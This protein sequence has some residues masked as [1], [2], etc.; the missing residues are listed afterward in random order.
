[1][2]VVVA[3]RVAGDTDQFR[4]FVTDEANADRLESVAATAKEQGAIHH[5]FAVGDGFVLVVDE[6]ESPEH[7]QRFFQGNPDVAAI[8]RDSGGQGEPEVT[9]AEYIETPDQF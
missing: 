7:F 6:W 9:F 2:S 4:S 3:V 5:R 8:V 1:M